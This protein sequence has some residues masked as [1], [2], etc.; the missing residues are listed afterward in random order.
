MTRK[1]KPTTGPVVVQVFN[2][3][4]IVNGGTTFDGRGFRALGERGR[5]DSATIVFTNAV[6]AE[7][8]LAD[9]VRNSANPELPNTSP[10][11]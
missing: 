3:F 5:I 7:T 10:I 6:D 1:T 8:A 4:L 2:H 9:L 11:S